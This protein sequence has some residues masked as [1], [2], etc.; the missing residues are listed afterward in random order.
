MTR[1][2]KGVCKHQH[3]ACLRGFGSVR[4]SEHFR[5]VVLRLSFLSPKYVGSGKHI[6]EVVPL[7]KAQINLSNAVAGAPLIWSCLLC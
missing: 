2:K 5:I 3:L 1:P 4:R 7:V 6:L